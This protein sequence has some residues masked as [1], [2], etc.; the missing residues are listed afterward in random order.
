MS[1]ERFISVQLSGL[2]KLVYISMIEDNVTGFLIKNTINRVYM[3]K[4]IN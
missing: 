3:F 4:T 2:Y 1:Q